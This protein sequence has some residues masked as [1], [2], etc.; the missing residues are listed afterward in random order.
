MD[1]ADLG[2]RIQKIRE[3]V[4]GQKQFELARDLGTVQTLISRLERGIGGNINL[5]IDFVNY[6]EKKGYPAHLLFAKDF[7][8]E[9]IKKENNKDGIVKNSIESQISELKYYMQKG[10]EKA[11]TLEN[12]MADNKTNIQSNPT[13]KN[14]EKK[15]HKK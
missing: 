6:L 5:M 15:V 2:S 9:L 13:S 8:V 4:L 11:I 10:F 7:G 1:L 3:Q 12:L 14:P